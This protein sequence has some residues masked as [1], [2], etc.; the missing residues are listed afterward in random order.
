VGVGSQNVT[1]ATDANKAIRSALDG[2]DH[3]VALRVMRDGTTA[4]VGVT[5]DQSAG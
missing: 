1:T 5:V 4:F 3:A 2:K